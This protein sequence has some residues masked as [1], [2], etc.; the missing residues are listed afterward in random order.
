M[1]RATSTEYVGASAIEKSRPGRVTQEEKM[2][3]DRAADLRALLEQPGIT[4][5]PG[6]YDCIT[7]RLAEQAGFSM[8]FSSG[9]GIAASLLGAPDIGLL[10]A[11]AI[12]D[13]VRY[14]CRAIDIPL[15]ADVET[16]Y[17][18][19]NN[20]IR[21][22]EDVIDN[23]ASGI[24][25]EDQEWPKRCGHFDGKKVIAPEEHVKKI[26]AAIRARG[27]S[28]LVIVARTDARAIH[29]LE[30]AIER[31]KAYA[32]AGAD[33][34][35]VEAP[36]SRQELEQIAGELKGV[37]LFANI[38]EGGKT[39]ELTAKALE[40]MGYKLC[41]FALSGLFASA[42]GLRKCFEA[43]REDGTTGKMLEDLSFHHFEKIVDMDGYRASEKAFG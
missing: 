10:T 34:V 32:D 4:I 40:E 17:G 18:N 24:I 27:G 2:E 43:L 15:I 19:V 14:L 23:G 11:T 5:A 13:R 30:N 29:G 8:V 26:R 36:Q 7:A 41:A 31:G 1:K 38:I 39:P 33:V 35:F 42:L 28:K 12:T 37:K 25:L 9:F 22:V 16:G 21:T 6:V 3:R 20:V